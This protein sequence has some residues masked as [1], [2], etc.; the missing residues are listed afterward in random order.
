MKPKTYYVYKVDVDGV[1]RYYG[2]GTGNRYLHATS[3]ESTCDELNFDI[4]TGKDV[5]VSFVETGLTSNEA[6][7]LERKL[8]ERDFS[9]IYN[10]AIAKSLRSEL[11]KVK[12]SQASRSYVDDMINFALSSEDIIKINNVTLKNITKFWKICEMQSA[13][14]GKK[15]DKNMH[16][17]LKNASTREFIDV[18]SDKYKTEC[19][20]IIGESSKAQTYVPI[21]VIFFAGKKVSTEFNFKVIDE[22]INKKIIELSDVSG[23][24]FDALNS[25]IDTHLTNMGKKTKNE[26]HTDVSRM[27]L[28]K[29]NPDIQSW[30]DASADELRERA[31]V[32]NGL[33]TALR[34]GFIKNW[35]HMKEVIEKL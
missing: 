31:N 30:N 26:I 10:K 16:Q 15:A 8:I 25:I 21:E 23:Y 11:E 19:V 9:S 13:Y 18:L 35:E 2:K 33:V 3:G 1:T 4:K 17:F 29:V 14:E 34:M 7:A 20:Q 22:F 28:K 12:S 5:S 24:E 6:M 27:L 32:E